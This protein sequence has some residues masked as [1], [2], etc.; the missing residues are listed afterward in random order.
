MAYKEAGVKL[1]NRVAEEI[2][3][4]GTVEQ[5]PKLEARNRMSMVVIPK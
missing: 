2:A 4:E 5:S 3:D 1:L